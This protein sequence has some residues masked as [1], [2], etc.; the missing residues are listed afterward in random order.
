VL[1]VLFWGLKTLHPDPDSLEN[2]NAAFGSVFNESESTTV[3]R[4]MFNLNQH[5]GLK[6]LSV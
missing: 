5:L 4:N 3:V 1:V 2:W 6:C